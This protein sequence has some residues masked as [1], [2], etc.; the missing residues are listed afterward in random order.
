MT[1][2]HRRLAGA[3]FLR[4]L[5]VDEFA[6]EAGVIMGDVNY[7]HPFREGNGRAQLRYLK[8]LAMQ[9]G[10]ALDLKR[11][12]KASWLAAS[13]ASQLADY[14]LMADVIRRAIERSRQ[15]PACDADCK[16]TAE[17]GS[18]RAPQRTP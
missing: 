3:K 10:N 4:G 18:P 11:I 9:A 1:D 14:A 15:R 17:R 12:D 2:V 5:S 8:Q 7:I 6:R 16:G 13:K